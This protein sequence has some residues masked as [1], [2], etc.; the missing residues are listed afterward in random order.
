MIDADDKEWERSSGREPFCY[1]PSS[2]CIHRLFDLLVEVVDPELV[3][4]AE[5]VVARPVWYQVH[6]IVERLAEMEV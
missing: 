4:V 6:P 2:N 1:V 3:E 5:D